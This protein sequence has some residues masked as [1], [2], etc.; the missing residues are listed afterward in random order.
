MLYKLF[1]RV[2]FPFQ[3]DGFFE[4]AKRSVEG[5]LHFRP[6]SSV[7]VTEDEWKKIKS[8]GL[9]DRFVVVETPKKKTTR[10]SPAEPYVEAP[11]DN[12]LLTENKEPTIEEK[13]EKS[14]KKKKKFQ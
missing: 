4:K 13:K 5:S 12:I 3:V 9:G 6:Y 1:V 2:N 8:D 10:K 7:T 14:K 11:T